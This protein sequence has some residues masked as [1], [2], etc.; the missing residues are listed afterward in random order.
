MDARET[1]IRSD[2]DRFCRST[3]IHDL[4]IGSAPE[5]RGR[6]VS[7]LV[8]RF[9]EGRRQ[10]SRQVLVNQKPRGLP[11]GANPLVRERLGRIC[12]SGSDLVLG[13]SVLV[14]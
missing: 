3:M 14:P 1:K 4:V 6:D 5:I 12:Q 10:R 2:E 8:L 13:Q 9:H 11:Y 7:R